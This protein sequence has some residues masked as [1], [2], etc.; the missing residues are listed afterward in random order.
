[1]GVVTISASYGAGGHEIG[2]AVAKQLGLP[3][4][5]RAIPAGVARK[6]G[7]PMHDVEGKD[8]AVHSGLWRV[9]A[10]M[11][12]APDFAGSAGAGTS[13]AD[14]RLLREHTEEVLREIAAGAGG[15]VLGRAGAIVLADAPN[16][17]HVRLDGP[18]PARAAA[19]ARIAGIDAEAAMRDLRDNDSA[20]HAYVRH[21]YRKDATDARHYH[22]VID[23][24]ALSWDVVTDLIVAA[25]KSRGVTA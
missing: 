17:L 14:E 16:A 2:P 9:F 13:I 23:S 18:A 8:E 19:H 12:A 11:A 5:D 3:F 22:L 25:A 10:S 21:F 1:V 20:R 24:C 4:L 15:V 7:V 6:L